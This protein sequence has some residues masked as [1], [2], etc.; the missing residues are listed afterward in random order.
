[1]TDVSKLSDT[2]FARLNLLVLYAEDMCDADM[3][4]AS[5]ALDPRIA[6]DG[7]TVAGI[8][9]GSDFA[10]QN[11]PH[12]PSRYSLTTGGPVR[13]GYLAYNDNDPSQ[14]V[15]AI[16]GTSGFWEWV[17]NID[18]VS[19]KSAPFPGRVEQGFVEIFQSMQLRP[20]GSNQSAPLADAIKNGIVANGQVLV[21]GHSLGSTLATF[22]SFE[23]ADTACLGADRTA[24]IM[25]ASPK[26]GDGDFTAG[27]AG[28]LSNYLVI[29]YQRD[30]VPKV[31]P[32]DIFH[33]DIYRTLPNCRILTIG[34]TGR[35][36]I[37]DTIGCN[38]HL[39]DYAAM[40]DSNVYIQ[41]RSAPGWAKSD[42]SDAQCI[43]SV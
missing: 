14:Y 19:V 26:V 20:L 37:T 28:R 35:V 34:K 11:S 30:I 36:T 40:L 9:T 16:R 38:H 24:A 4:P 18:F 29:N 1:M 25:Y 39:I 27:Y 7:W 41:A 12:N 10:R 5:D 42:D 6:A 33:L 2:D 15:A 13:F 32:F 3:K 43:Q 31:P 23:L 8:I 22:L 17:D 21:L